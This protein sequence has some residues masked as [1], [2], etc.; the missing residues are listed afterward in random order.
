MAG[1][2]APDPDNE[3]QLSPFDWYGR[4]DENEERPEGPAARRR[5]TLAQAAQ[6]VDADLGRDKK[7]AGPR[8]IVTALF[9]ASALIAAVVFAEEATLAAA[10]AGTVALIAAV[11]SAFYVRR[12]LSASSE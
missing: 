8:A 6:R 11:T 3:P 12:A 10:I 1:H 7:E 9:A 4:T 5:R 2:P